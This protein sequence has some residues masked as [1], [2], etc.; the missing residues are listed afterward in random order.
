MNQ[1][2]DLPLGLFQVLEEEYVSLHGRIDDDGLIRVPDHSV[3]AGYRLVRAK[4]DWQF[5]RGHLKNPASLLDKLMSVRAQRVS[6]TSAAAVTGGQTEGWDA[7]ASGTPAT[8]PHDALLRY[9]VDRIP[10]NTLSAVVHQRAHLAGDL[11]ALF[12]E[13]AGDDGE[14]VVDTAT[15]PVA[16]VVQRARRRLAPGHL[17]SAEHG[18]RSLET[19]LNE[20]IKKELIYTDERFSG[21]RL[22][23]PLAAFFVTNTSDNVRSSD[24]PCV[25]RLL[26][27]QAFPEEIESVA[28]VR[29]AAIQQRFHATDSAALCLS[30]GGIRSATFAL[31]LLQSLARRNLVKEF[32]YLSTVSGGGYIA[33]WLTAWLYRDPKGLTGVTARL[34]NQPPETRIDPDP[35]PLRYLR[36]YS[37]F[38][39]PQTGL[40][41]GDTWTFV[42]MYLRNLFLNWT[43]IVP[44]LLAFLMIP[45]LY[46]SALME[47]PDTPLFGGVGL[48]HCFLAIAGALSIAAVAYTTI[49]QPHIRQQ[50]RARSSFW[51]KRSGQ[52]SFLRW[53]LLPLVTAAVFLSLFWAW[54]LSSREAGDAHNW[55]PY[56]GFGLIVT[57]AGWTVAMVILRRFR[58]R[59]WRETSP[60]ELLVLLLVGVVGATLFWGTEWLL[61]EYPPVVRDITADWRTWRTELYAVLAVPVFLGGFLVAMTLFIGLTSHQKKFPDEDREWWARA[62]AWILVA[63]VA[64]FVFSTLVIFGPLALT[65][66][67]KLIT[68]AG[69]LSGLVALIAGRSSRTHAVE[70]PGARDGL[71]AWIHR[72]GLPALAGVFLLVFAASLAL[73]TSALTVGLANLAARLEPSAWLSSPVKTL[74]T[75][76]KQFESAGGFG[77]AALQDLHMWS[78]HYPLVRFTLSVTVLLSAVGWFMSWRI[79]LNRFTLHAGYRDRLIRAFL[80]ASRQVAER[81]P[82]PFTGLDP[83]DNIQMHE[84]RPALFHEGDFA[85]IGALALKLRAGGDDVSAH[86]WS[87]LTGTVK[88]ELESYSVDTLPSP[89]LKTG[90]IDDINHI[91]QDYKSP[92]FKEA[93]FQEY[94]GREAV[95]SKGDAT[96][97]P[98]G[99]YAILLNRRLLQAAY[100]DEIQKKYPP[101]HRLFHVVNTA[102]NL[103]GGDNLAW[104][105]RKAEPFSITPLHCGCY[106]LGYRRS[107]EYGG[108]DGISLGTAVAISGAA[109]SSNMGYY[110]TS[111]VISMVMTLFNVRL[112]WW[113]GNPGPAGATTYKLPS[114]KYSIAP[115]VQEAFG[116]TDDKNKY[117]YLSDGGHFE[118][119]AL[120]EMVLR[121]CRIIV[122]S[123]GG[124]DEEYQFNDL[125]NAIRKIRIDLGIPI[126][127]KDVP[128]HAVNLAGNHADQKNGTRG[129]YFAI[130]NIG[131]SCVDV[132]AEDGVLL[133]VKPAIYGDEPQDVLHY[134]R[135]H[136]TFPHE[137]TADQFFDE[138]QFESYR[139][140]GSFIMNRVLDTAS[141]TTDLKSVVRGLYAEGRREGHASWPTIQAGWLTPAR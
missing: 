31:G 110:T 120:Y 82:N 103:V 4:R 134:K 61:K 123:D 86:L 117:V 58:R 124:A 99:D 138:A 68:A 77:L 109:A 5:H 76:E 7:T 62:K 16:K 107:L 92:L 125:G 60:T 67:P 89:S 115:V 27:E 133:Y 85:N 3:D 1:E 41:S 122:V 93:V 141:D 20:I 37:N 126:E 87:R 36:S 51:F 10:A 46:V 72:I 91:L 140:L 131:Y 49:N 23:G 119:L 39:T 45:R 6:V 104:Q 8:G 139:A 18:L 105:Q 113:L 95:T 19:A 135:S 75:I 12:D 83:A 127:F 106:R 2:A 17:T 100:S 55:L 102:L 94:L 47:T 54:S 96:G 73:L 30:G 44:L 43:V 42:A 70:Q 71:V 101:P 65:Y 53:C 25:N 79:Q 22:S 13:P 129:S 32:D 24:W 111:P 63:S 38:I 9:L 28:N 14:D 59:N 33:S 34:A 80:G 48:G 114:P 29:L 69:G 97:E 132:G 118:N 40:L 56:G 64:W 90:L 66:S 137:T 35:E 130:A 128:I 136:A 108:E 52:G 121:R 21:I 88:S 81:R 74:L 15:A 50:L 116:L 57:F 98:S 84:L 26:L 78:I 11:N 112:G